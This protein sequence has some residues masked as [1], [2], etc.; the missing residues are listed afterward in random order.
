MDPKGFAYATAAYAMWGVLPLYWRLLHA[1]PPLTVLANRVVWTALASTLVLVQRG[2]F[3]DVMAIVRD[4]RRAWLAFAGTLLIASNWFCFIWG[5][6]AGRTIEC[7]LGYFL[8]P[9]VNVVLGLGV[10]RERITRLQLG[11][12]ALAAIGVAWLAAAH[13]HVPWLGLALAVSFGVYGLCRKLAKIPSLPGLAFE[14]LA[15]APIALAW[16]TDVPV[17][18]R[19]PL[20]LVLLAGAGVATALP[21]LWFNEAAQRMPLTVLGVLQY[22]APTGQFLVGTLVFHEAFSREKLVAFAFI[23]VG[24]ALYTADGF[25]SWRSSAS[26]PAR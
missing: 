22:L 14:T 21:L 18:A 19:T 11:A 4:R 9:L 2:S 16:A 6:H 5:I 15:L 3:G 26:S 23:W 25:R 7:S 24:L 10:L 13:G 17:D 1:V 20:T 8:S 12:V